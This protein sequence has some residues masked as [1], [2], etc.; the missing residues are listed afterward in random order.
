MHELLRKAWFWGQDDSPDWFSAYVTPLIW[1]PYCW[2]RGYHTP[3]HC[4]AYFELCTVCLRVLWSSRR[5][6]CMNPFILE[7]RT[8]V[9][10]V[11]ITWRAGR[12][13]RVTTTPT[14]Y[15]RAEGEDAEEQLR[16]VTL[17]PVDEAT[18]TW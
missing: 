9:D 12:A 15:S 2:A 3:H 6:A 7:G 4:D 10:H 8:L 13:T 1:Q 11:N 17:H 18:D 14:A 5:D 16:T